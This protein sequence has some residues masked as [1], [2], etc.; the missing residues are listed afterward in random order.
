MSKIIKELYCNPC[1]MHVEIHESRISNLRIRKIPSGIRISRNDI[2]KLDLAP[3]EILDTAYL[4]IEAYY[5][6]YN[7]RK[8][9][10]TIE[11]N[12]KDIQ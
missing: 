4:L 12:I 2:K 8:V 7:D 10:I 5:L 9:S 11:A 3:N 6:M 1:T